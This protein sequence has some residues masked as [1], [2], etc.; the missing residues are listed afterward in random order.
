[1]KSALKIIM[2]FIFLIAVVSGLSAYWTFYRVVP[3][4]DNS[5]KLPGLTN[6]VVVSWDEH[7]IPHITASED[8]DVF[9]TMGYLHAR[10]RL[11]QMT[12]KQYKLEGLH[13]RELDENLNDIDRFYL[14]MSFGELARDAFNQ[15]PLRSRQLLEAYANGVNHYIDKNR[16][17]LSV[18]FA[19]SDA[20]PVTWEPW[21]A[22]GAKI[23]WFWEHQ[24]AFWTKPAL[25]SLHFL[26][27]AGATRALTGMDVPHQVLFGSEK[28]VFDEIS[29]DLLMDE[30]L[31]FTEPVKP[32]VSGLTGTGMALSRQSP[33]SISMLYT[34]GES[35]LNVPDQGYELI[36]ESARGR[37]AGLTVPG[38]P[39]M[40]SGQNETMAWSLKP[41]QLDDGNFFTDSLFT[42]PPAQ[43]VDWNTDPGI[44]AYLSKDITLNRHILT[45]KNGGEKQ[46]VT[47]K[48]KG[49]PV[50]ALA[51]GRNRYLAFEWAGLSPSTDITAFMDLM[52]VNDPDQLHNL[53]SSISSPAVQVL[54]TS[55]GGQAGRF[56]AGKVFTGRYPLSIRKNEAESEAAD[57][58]EFFNDLVQSDGQ[59]VFPLVKTTS[60]REHV[61]HECLFSPPFDRSERLLELLSQTPH[62]RIAIDMMTR[63]HR[64]TYSHF[65]AWHSPLIL[66][67]L[68]HFDGDARIEAILPYLQNWNHEFGQNE[69]AATLFQ[70]FI[71]YAGRNLYRGY[72]DEKYIEM[73][74]SSP[75]IPYSVVAA[76]LKD[77]DKWPASH[78]Y[79]YS[80]WVFESISGAIRYLSDKYGNELHTWQ[81]QRIVDGSF[82]DVLFD[83]TQHSSKSARLA[84][85]NLFKP[86]RADVSGSPHSLQTVHLSHNNG[87]TL[88]G[89]TTSKRIMTLQPENMFV[90][91]LST[92]QSGHVFSDH[93][94]DQFLLWNEGALKSPVHPFSSQS[95]KFEHI[96]EFEP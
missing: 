73:V 67:H 34:T 94:S 8:A 5:I 23:L 43:S 56:H 93:Y 90:S 58:S 78:P 72:L 24:Q 26:Q 68:K 27:D 77:P 20:N 75:N 85:R 59:P 82:Q 3:S 12:L 45:L 48:A 39:A 83:E 28:P 62:D 46:I 79:S 35:H 55:T 80:E 81:W 47:K 17:H 71:V 50:V 2:L 4:L 88:A 54:F 41:L 32:K 25:A 11:W 96:Q 22:V 15:M 65:A 87:A 84:E 6:K 66:A 91:V 1:M 76:L 61:S 64:D 86:G 14:T 18:E 53:V 9:M 63:W 60:T 70:L 74:Y 69:T 29:Y 10:D 40:I 95:R 92:G 51:E 19:L 31:D 52:H 30:F 38:F 7:Q 16:K 37:S 36:V 21:H 42:G 13:S 49:H 33:H 89:A 44:L 57:A